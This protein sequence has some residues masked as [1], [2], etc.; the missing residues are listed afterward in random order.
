MQGNPLV[1]IIIPTFNR[2]H[3]IGETLDSVLAQ[4]YTN[5]ECIVVDD[6]STDNTASVLQSYIDKDSR[7]QYHH[8]PK[9]RLPGGNAARNYGFELSSGEY[10]QWFDDDDLMVPEKLEV[11][12]TYLLDNKVDFVMSKT[13]YFN[14][15]GYNNK[16]YGYNYSEGDINFLSFV[17][18]HIT[19][20]TNDMIIKR[21]VAEKISFNEVLKSG[22][23]FNFSCKLLL[24]TNSLKKV[25]EFLTLKRFHKISIGKKR[26][27]DKS[28]YWITSFD[29]HW[30]NYNELN[31][32][33]IIPKIFNEYTLLKCVKS[34]LNE[35]EIKLSYTFHKEMFKV[36]KL[37]VVYFYLSVISKFM[38]GR[39]Y[40]FY[41]HLKYIK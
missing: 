11:K 22:Q 8:R 33:Y 41:K 29:L 13:K 18:T 28:H 21:S 2:A 26:Q 7:F 23:E 38:F 12:L 31:R 24:E 37:K 34:Y 17:M 16:S 14:K 19:W 15:N 3:L 4:T 36:F 35:S 10:I 20:V 32:H 27:V 5:W 39:Y 9:N 1:S 40:V 25:D 6:G 30:V